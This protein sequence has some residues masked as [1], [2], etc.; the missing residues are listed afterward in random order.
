MGL[1]ASEAVPQQATKSNTQINSFAVRHIIG[2]WALA[3]CACVGTVFSSFLC[4]ACIFQMYVR[5]CVCEAHTWTLMAPGLG[6]SSSGLS[7]ERLWC[8]GSPVLLTADSLVGLLW[9]DFENTHMWKISKLTKNSL[10]T[11]NMNCF[12]CKCRQTFFLSSNLIIIIY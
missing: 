4:Y 8:M 10:Y 9:N 11:V 3:A 5:A 1:I 12:R 7:L 2:P 6:G